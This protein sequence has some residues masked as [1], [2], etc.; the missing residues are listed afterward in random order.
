MLGF[1]TLRAFTKR[2][3]L[4]LIQS[5]IVTSRLLLIIAV[6][7][8]RCEKIHLITPRAGILVFRIRETFIIFF[9]CSGFSVFVL[10]QS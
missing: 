5:N 9:I 10:L 2:F 1:V 4:E 6:T 3:L 7:K 8:V